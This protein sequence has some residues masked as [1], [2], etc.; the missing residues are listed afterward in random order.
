VTEETTMYLAIRR[1]LAQAR[2]ADQ[3]CQALHDAA[4][5]PAIHYDLARARIDDVYDE[6]RHQALA[7]AAS[8]ARR[9]AP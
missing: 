3:Y 8:R 6:V 7:G 1:R 2:L 4:L 5:H 9:Y